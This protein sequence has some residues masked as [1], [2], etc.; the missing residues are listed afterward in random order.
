MEGLSAGSRTFDGFATGVARGGADFPNPGRLVDETG[1]IGQATVARSENVVPS[2]GSRAADG[3]GGACRPPNSF[4][5][6][7]A[8]LMA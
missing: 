3:G 6:G 1:D 8:V 4:V 7:T 2:S 5:A